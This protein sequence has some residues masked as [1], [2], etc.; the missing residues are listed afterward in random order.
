MI[1]RIS[2]AA[3]LGTFALASC[4][5]STVM[6]LGETGSGG[7]SSGGAGG[8]AAGANSGGSDIA[9]EMDAGAAA[10]ALNAGQSTPLAL[11]N[12]EYDN[13]VRDLLGDASMPS[14]VMGFTADPLE[15]GFQRN[16]A[17]VDMA[18]TSQY[19]KAAENLALNAEGRLAQGHFSEVL[20]CNPATIGEDAC[21]TQFIATFGRRAFRRS[22]TSAER[23]EMQQIYLKDKNANDFIH[24]IRIVIESMLASPRFFEIESQGTAPGIAPLGPFQLA[25]RLSYFIYRSMPDDQLLDAAETSQLVTKDDIAREARRMLADAKAHAGVISFF[26][27]WLSLDR[28][29]TTTKD[30]SV[31]ASFETLKGD[32]ATE[33]IKF[34][35][36]I[37]YGDGQLKSLFQS[38]TTWVNAPLANLY[39]QAGVADQ[40]QQ[41]QLDPKVRA[42]I[43]TQAS[44]LSIR[45]GPK[46]GSPTQ[47]GV[48]VRDNVLCQ[49]IPFSP[50]NTPPLL[51]N[52]PGQTNR[53]RYEAA[54]ASPSCAACHRLI[55]PIGYGLEAFD[56]VGR[57]R[58]VDNGLPVDASGLVVNFDLPEPFNGAVEL[59][60]KL[61]DS[62]VAKECAAKQ[63]F[64]FALSRAESEEDA[65]SIGAATRVMENSGNL[66]EL[67][68]E[69]ATSDSFRYARW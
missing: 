20:P 8:L 44:F 7:S 57:Y 58:T 65:C 36:S 27:E 37:F 55:D 19:V 39:G 52:K 17:P 29:T 9:P 21:A 62:T 54:M 26:S 22:L 34:V 56:T 31:L 67:V 1:P 5:G 32:M 68:I 38:S 49:T 6:H 35:E 45:G 64:R 46:N 63:W 66:R 25:S 51:E 48:F 23:S 60:A 30:P 69:I 53:Q 41:V 47:R 3:L 14:V 18:R 33:T 16:T 24:A 2:Q 28:L 50:A 13:T 59:A 61:A 11:T 12:F 4:G 42:G 10:C 40:F 43:L 15:A